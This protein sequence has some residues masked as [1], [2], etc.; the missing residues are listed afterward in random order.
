MTNE[1]KMRGYIKDPL[2]LYDFHIGLWE[3]VGVLIGFFIAYR[4]LAFIFLYS[5]K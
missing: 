1:I 5:L 2:E 3:C 4:I